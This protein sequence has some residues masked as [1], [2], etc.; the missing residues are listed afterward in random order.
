M[1]VL[2]AL[3]VFF[4]T[5]LCMWFMGLWN[6]VLTLCNILISTLFASSLWE[7]VANTIE[8]LD[9]T[10]TY[11]ADFMAAWAVFFLSFIVIRFLAEVLCRYKV[12]FPGIVDYLG[13]TVA[14]IAA[15]WILMCFTMFTMH[16]APAPQSIFAGGPSD[17]QLL[18]GPDRLWL[19]FVHSR[20]KGALAEMKNVP[21]VPEYNI[22]SHP[23]DS[24]LNCRVFD[25]WADFI[26]KY[27]HR[28]RTWS[29][30]EQVRVFRPE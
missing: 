17:Q 12:Q 29:Q 8:S 14:S 21:F 26:Y 18:I 9:G 15:A 4:I 1:L 25:P 11:V 19:R 5:I 28:R 13:R 6:N 22:K 23:D 7:P 10:Y 27:R 3:S 20:S 24:H 16:M 30:E 2:I